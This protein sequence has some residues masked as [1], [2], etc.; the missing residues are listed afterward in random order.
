LLYAVK[1]ISFHFF[2]SV[3]VDG[4]TEFNSFLDL[5]DHNFLSGVRWNVHSVEAGSCG[6]KFLVDS[7]LAVNLNRHIKGARTDTALSCHE[8]DEHLT[9]FFS[10][11]VLKRFPEVF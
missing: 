1:Y 11:V 9:V 2:I 7:F 4:R 5:L 3:V 6:R 10:K 8:F